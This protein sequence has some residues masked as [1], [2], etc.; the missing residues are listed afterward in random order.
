MV[1]A[2]VPG[3]DPP[4][5]SPPAFA[6]ISRYIKSAAV[7]IAPVSVVIKYSPASTSISK[8]K[9]HLLVANSLLALEG[10]PSVIST[11]FFGVP[12]VL[13]TL[14]KET[15]LLPV[16]LEIEQKTTVIQPF[17]CTTKS[18]PG[19]KSEV[20]VVPS[21]VKFPGSMLLSVF[22]QPNV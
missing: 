19:A 14:Y 13:S 4:P 1:Y 10:I 3:V 2:P 20:Y 9:I 17:L 11:P 6:P 15:S 21:I 8:Y 7:E 22:V 18:I 12:S 16:S 5:L